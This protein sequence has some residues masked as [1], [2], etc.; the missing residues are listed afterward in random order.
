MKGKL[1]SF[2]DQDI[3]VKKSSREL[4]KLNEKKLAKLKKLHKTAYSK[5]QA[6]HLLKEQHGI[7]NEGIK[8]LEIGPTSQ[9]DLKFISTT[10][11]RRMLYTILGVTGDQLRDSKLIAEDVK[12][13]L[14]RGQVEKAVFLARL[15]KK[16]GA[17]AMN[18]IMEYYFYDLKYPQ[19]AIQ[20]FNWRKKWGIPPNEY[21]NTIL[22]KGLAQQ[23]QQISKATANL[24]TRVVDGLISREEL[25]QIEFNAALGAL[26]NSTDVTQ[27]FELFE[28]RVKGIRP[29]AITYLWMLRAC[30]R[31]KTDKLFNSVLSK[32]VEGIPS[33]CVDSRLLFEFCKTLNSRPEKESKQLALVA[34]DEYYDFGKGGKLSPKVPEGLSFLPLSH[35]SIEDKFPISK[36]TLGLLLANCIQTGN[37]KFGIETFLRFKRDNNKLIDVDMFH[38][39]MQLLMK[40]DPATCGEKCLKV[41]EEMESIKNIAF[42]KHSLILVYSSLEKQASKKII[43]SDEL[44]IDELLAKCQDFIKQQE[45]IYSKELENKVYPLKSWQFLASIIK[46]ANSS[47]KVSLSRY[48]LLI[49]EFLRTLCHGLLDFKNSR[50]GEQA[51]FI[52]LEFVRLLKIFSDKLEVPDIEDVDTSVD[53]PEREAFL[54][55]RLV[56]RLKDKLLQHIKLIETGKQKSEDVDEL[57]WSMK[58]IA[59]R[60]F[61]IKT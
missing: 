55:R 56:L 21:T 7:A 5:Q 41:F 31:I 10:R 36:H 24:V 11:D 22:F 40:D 26:A 29:D 17:A 34:L 9:S 58:Q 30:S 54:L 12:K 33:R 42:S 50:V 13:F 8:E 28:K 60:I 51:R 44:K 48:K 2:K 43:N 4:Q 15:A 32:T 47:N 45:G 14:K 39:Y 46:H 6:V 52:E 37:W 53:G 57:E 27:A 16:K 25:S 59:H 20:M 23:E 35:W 38:K 19:S 3:L 61:T 1:N 18:S 49:D